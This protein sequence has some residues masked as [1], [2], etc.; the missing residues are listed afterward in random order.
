MLTTASRDTA[1]Y[2]RHHITINEHWDPQMGDRI[3]QANELL[4]ALTAT[5]RTEFK[6]GGEFVNAADV[7]TRNG[8]FEAFSGTQ[9]FTTEAPEGPAAAQWQ[10]ANYKMS[11][12]HSWHQSI[13]NSGGPE[14]M[15]FD[16]LQHDIDTLGLSYG[17]NLN[18]VLRS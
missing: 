8:T 17:D 3:A 9:T 18:V 5:G 11:L 2:N 13:Q 4:W 10:Y 14:V 1:D 12:Q 16:Q 15:R 6:Q 7:V